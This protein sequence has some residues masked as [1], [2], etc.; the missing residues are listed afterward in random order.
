MKIQD[1][2]FRHYD[3]QDM[4]DNQS[5][6]VPTDVSVPWRDLRDAEQHRP[7][8]RDIEITGIRT[9]T[10]EGCYPWGIVKVETN[11]GEYG[12]GETFHGQE[13]LDVVK[14]F[15]KHVIGENPLDIDRITEL[16]NQRYTGAGGI[17]QSAI[18]G[19]E[20]ALWDLKGK[21]L[22]VP[23]YELF[24]GKFRD[25][26]QVYVDTH[27][28]GSVGETTSGNANEAY[29]PEAYAE[30]ARAVVDDGF[31]ALKF[32]LDVPTPGHREMDAAARRLDNAAI[33]HK[34]DLVEAVRAEI[35]Y[36][37]DLGVD[38]HWNFTVETALRLGEKLERFDLAFIE[39]PVPPEKLDAQRRVAEQLRTPVLTGENVGKPSGFNDL[40]ANDVLDIAAPDVNKCG[41]LSALHRIATVCDL[42]GVPIA[43]HTLSSPVGVIAG[44]HICAA[45][46]NFMSI[47]YRGH[48]V[49]WWDDLVTR[50]GGDG[51][52]IQDGFIDVP[53]GPGLGVE[54]DP[55]VASEYLAADSEL[56]T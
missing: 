36:D 9:M 8:E 5:Y 18:T 34:V 43:P 32:D 12:I 42:Y 22:D 51:P 29:T 46:P 10:V 23:I 21:L 50:T 19:I 25:V 14:R 24:G 13:S 47:E 15:Q 28:G 3:S 4:P 7:P 54:I 55:D 31:Q 52:I 41:G 27:A 44:S 17:G 11:A 20:I 1:L 38:L 53:E 33:Q 35:G 49:P 45:V 56:I 39:D 16:L 48:D 2:G 6:Q 26:I 40:V 30:A 37:V